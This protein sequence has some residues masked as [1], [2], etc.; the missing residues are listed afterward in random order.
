ML[1]EHTNALLTGL[2]STEPIAAGVVVRSIVVQR[3]RAAVRRLLSSSSRS[4]VH[5]VAENL[6]LLLKTPVFQTWTMGAAFFCGHV[7]SLLEH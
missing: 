4:R 6:I 3:L 1:D 7:P 2:K 5:Y